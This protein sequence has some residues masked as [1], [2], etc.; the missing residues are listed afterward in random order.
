MNPLTAN[1]VMKMQAC[2]LRW[3]R[4]CEA[5]RATGERQK[6]LLPLSHHARGCVLEI[7]PFA[8]RKH[9]GVIS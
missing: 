1:A 9:A 8:L 3:L 2:G 5:E 4:A 7:S 6:G